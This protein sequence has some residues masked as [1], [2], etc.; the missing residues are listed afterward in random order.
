MSSLTARKPAPD[1]VW[2]RAHGGAP[3]TT[4]AEG[5]APTSL[6]PRTPDRTS[7]SMPA[8]QPPG[9]LMRPGETTTAPFCPP[10]TTT[11]TTTGPDGTTGGAPWG[12]NPPA[13][14]DDRTTERC[15]SRA[16]DNSFDG[17]VERR[18]HC[19]LC[20]KVVCQNCSS[21]NAMLPPEWRI[22]EPQRVC[23]DCFRVVLPFQATWVKSN[24][25]AERENFLQDDDTTKYLNS[26]LRFTLGGEIRKAAYTIQNLTDPQNV[27]FWERDVEYTTELLEAVEGLLF[28]TVG[29][30]AFIGGVRVGTGLVVARLAD[31]SWSAPCAVGSFG[32]TF[33]A[34]VGAEVTDFVT[35]L[36]SKAVA[37][38]C[39][40]QTSKVAMGGEVSFAF[41]PLGRTAGGEAIVS[42]DANT[43]STT[44]YAQSRGFY[45]GVTLDAAYVKV[46]DDVNLKF[47]GRTVSAA[48]LLRGLEKQPNAAGPLY[49]QLHSFYALLDGRTSLASRTN[50]TGAAP[51]GAGAYPQAAAA[52][53]SQSSSSSWGSSYY[54]SS[55]AP[56][57]GG[58]GYP[59][60]GGG[61]PVVAAVP[62]NQGYSAVPAPAPPP[63]VGAPGAVGDS[64]WGNRQTKNPF[65]PA[66]VPA[67]QQPSRG[68][69]VV[70]V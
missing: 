30:I 55:S 62:V 61:P 49:E 50:P 14:V 68:P 21:R 17:I 70:E 67:Q 1:E 13:W 51:P 35:P 46:R 10:A 37:E 20:G 52:Q 59:P 48:D 29:K 66:T 42:S 33:G 22:K 12:P 47:Y 27:N 28:M 45:G 32:V 9:N 36:D 41:G 57:H 15:M 43:A 44:S 31:A 39:D 24:A 65:A 60:A 11:T 69:D 54:G 5:A 34:V 40:E 53:G 26:P 19:R 3:S 8:V 58:T 18:H 4:P 6:A 7:S 56:A 64:L 23:N 2:L 63:A 38:F 25:N 16:C